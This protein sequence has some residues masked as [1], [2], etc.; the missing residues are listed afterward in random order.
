MRSD[1]RCD[2]IIPVW[3]EPGLTKKCVDSIRQN[4]SLPYKIVI[5]DNASSVET[6]QCLKGL[7]EKG[8]ITL[9]R[10]ERNLG[11]PAA[12]NQGMASLDAPYACIL[13]ND[14]AVYRGWL[15]EMILIA[16]GDSSIGI[17]NPASNNLGQKGPEPGFSGKWIE[18]AMCTGFCMLIKR[19]LIE[20]IGNFDEIY[21]PGNFEDADFSKRAIRAGYKCVMARGAYVHHEENTS[22]KKRKDWNK[23]FKRNREIFNKRWGAPERIVYVIGEDR[24]GNLDVIKRGV[25]EFLKK[26]DWVWVIFRKSSRKIDM[27]EHTSLSIF[28]IGKFG[29]AIKVLWRVIKRKKRFSEVMTDSG[30]LA[31][32]FKVLGYRVQKI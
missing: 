20:K 1:I 24:G 3:D 28:E 31:G 23:G 18:M 4:T 9:I 32:F 8:W 13:N 30:F 29:F 27:P 26:G 17:V 2:I 10:N 12:V 22:F 19:T 14:T 6:A 25:R 11:F 21:S 15:R 5:I 16:E 7:S